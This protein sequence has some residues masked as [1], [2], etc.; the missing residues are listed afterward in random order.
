MRHI[1]MA[2]DRAGRAAW[3]VEQYR[4]DRAR[5]APSQGVRRYRFDWQ[6]ETLEVGN[7]PLEATGRTINRG[8]P[9]PGG[10][11]LRGLTA[12]RGAEID[13]LVSGNATEQARRQ[14]SSCILDPP[15]TLS[16]S[17][18]GDKRATGRPAQRSGWQQYSLELVTPYLGI[19]AQCQIERGL[20]QM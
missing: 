20:P 5:W 11:K 7:E 4:I 13:D 2:T 10:G 9:G 6:P 8:D 14:C 3:R 12:R 19:V 16:I 18:Q 15:G 1:R 17:R